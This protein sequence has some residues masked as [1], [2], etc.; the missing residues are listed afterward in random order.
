MSCLQLFPEERV[1][2]ENTCFL[3]PQQKVT[4]SPPGHSI[5]VI[6]VH[7]WDLS[8]TEF[9][10]RKDVFLLLFYTLL[11]KA[12]SLPEL[13]L[14]DP[15]SLPSILDVSLLVSVT[16]WRTVLFASPLVGPQTLSRTEQ[17]S[18]LVNAF[19]QIWMLKASSISCDL[20][21]PVMMNVDGKHEI[22]DK[23]LSQSK[24]KKN[25]ISWCSIRKARQGRPLL[26][27]L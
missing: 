10:E 4:C 25:R 21:T 15:S 9:V 11:G 17:H 20:R 27:L 14:H 22:C 3:A 6:G 8:H 7:F 24:R 23:P 18:I 5:E 13:W 19:V 1:L 16:S 12:V 26:A 2:I